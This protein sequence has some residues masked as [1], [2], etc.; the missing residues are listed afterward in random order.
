[1]GGINALQRNGLPEDAP[2]VH[3]RYER[4]TLAIENALADILL[5]DP[6]ARAVIMV[7]AYAPCAAFIKLARAYELDAIFLNVSFVG[8]A[9]LAEALGPEGEGVV[10]TQVVPHIESEAPIV[11][12]YRAA[13]SGV[14]PT[15]APTF[16]S[17]EGYIV[18][19]ILTKA[20]LNLDAPPTRETIVEALEALGQFDIGLGVP[21]RLGPSEHQ[22]CHR[23]W[24][25]IIHDGKVVPLDWSS[26]RELRKRGKS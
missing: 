16:G 7:G 21:L 3:G 1:V 14:D 12:T 5:A 8:S 23:V 17:L 15:A 24:P 25:T 26:L 11:K 20:M 2:V 4:N 22:A 19:R 9:P 6:P 13:L 18:G 10:I